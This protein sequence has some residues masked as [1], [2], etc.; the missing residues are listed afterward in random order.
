MTLACAPYRG[1]YVGVLR[2]KN[3][4]SKLDRND[5]TYKL[6]LFVT[7]LCCFA[8]C[9]STIGCSRSALTIK[10]ATQIII[11]VDYEALKIIKLLL[12]IQALVL[13]LVLL[14]LYLHTN[15][16]ILVAE[17]LP[18]S[19]QMVRIRGNTKRPKTN[20]IVQVVTYS[21]LYI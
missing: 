4:V 8:P 13:M 1:A 6:F 21:T 12:R 7:D 9:I 15:L 2:Y 17:L 16:I 3:S 18:L 19:R 11:V 5:G 14:Y 20:V 10:G